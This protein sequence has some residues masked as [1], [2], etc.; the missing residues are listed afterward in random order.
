MLF[1]GVI[2]TMWLVIQEWIVPAFLLNSNSDGVPW[3]VTSEI[4]FWPA[5]FV[6]VVKLPFDP[7]KS[8]FNRCLSLR[9]PGPTS[10][11]V[12]PGQYGNFDC[13]G[14]ILEGGQF[15]SLAQI[16]LCQRDG[17]YCRWSRILHL[18]S[19]GYQPKLHYSEHQNQWL[20]QSCLFNTKKLRLNTSYLL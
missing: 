20:L 19:S 9:D 2:V 15:N 17:G 16:T 8:Y 7:R 6:L 3:L 14:P 13:S 1:R 4:L 18:C 12:L 11:I 5:Q 10:C